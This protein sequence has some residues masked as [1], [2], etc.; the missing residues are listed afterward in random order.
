MRLLFNLHSSLHSL[1]TIAPYL[2]YALLLSHPHYTAHYIA[3]VKQVQTL[4]DF[5][6]FLGPENSPMVL[7]LTRPQALLDLVHPTPGPT[8]LTPLSEKAGGSSKV[9]P[10]PIPNVTATAKLLQG[11]VQRLDLIFKTGNNHIING[12]IYLSSDFS[13]A[14]SSSALFWSPDVAPLLTVDKVNWTPYLLDSIAYHPI[15]LNSSYQPAQPLI[16]PYILPNTYY[17]IPLFLRSEI[18]GSYKLRLLTEYVPK[19][20]HSATVSKEVELNVSFLKPLN[21]NF[22]LSSEREAQCGVVREGFMSTLL[23]G[24][25]VNMAASLGCA[26]ALGEEIQILGMTFMQPPQVAQTEDYY[27]DNSNI[28]DAENDQEALES[29]TKLLPHLFRL[30]DGAASIN[31]LHPVVPVP[32]PA[33]TANLPTASPSDDITAPSSSS[34]GAVESLEGGDKLNGYAA[35]TQLDNKS[36]PHLGGALDPTSGTSTI[37]PV[38]T[39]RSEVLL[40]K[41][42]VYVCSTDIQ[43]V[44]SSTVPS[45]PF[46]VQI[47]SMGDLYVD[48]R[49]HNDRI[50]SPPDL[51]RWVRSKDTRTSQASA[52]FNWLLQWGPLNPPKEDPSESSVSA[53][54]RRTSTTRVCGMVFSV[55]RVKISPAPFTVMIN[56]ATTCRRNEVLPLEIVINNKLW[57]PEHLSLAIDIRMNNTTAPSSSAGSSGTKTEGASD[58]TPSSASASGPGSTS[59][60]FLVVGNASSLLDVSK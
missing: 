38:I 32:A 21:M 40:K 50:L 13:P 1:L 60:G 2:I 58:S 3:S 55:P 52:S 51:S 17:C 33:S 24:D 48:W 53:I 22:S 30:A 6:A 31:L 54:D 56:L 28:N 8:P 39:E 44:E 18:Q 25:M 11:P 12:R 5:R 20:G 35:V 23:E 14:S 29:P 41:G 46:T 10:K 15:L 26:N 49:L 37:P 16:L 4:N 45:L 59:C 34:D 43:C 27:D 47:A 36:A 19:K 9:S 42:E 7:Q 57:T